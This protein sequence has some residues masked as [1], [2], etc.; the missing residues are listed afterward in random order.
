MS[1]QHV[2]YDVLADL[3]EGLLEELPATSVRAHL[4]E[5]AECRERSADLASV[6]R[7][8]AS[9]PMPPMPESLAA[10]LDAAILAE[11]KEG[12]PVIDLAARRRIRMQRILSV[13]AA[14]TVVSGAGLAI[15]NG[16]LDTGA[17]NGT[18]ALV[19]E[20]REPVPV[21]STKKLPLV[22]SPTQY[23]KHTLAAQV[24]EQLRKTA[25]I[26]PGT[27]PGRL[28]DCVRSVAGASAPVLLV[29]NAWFDGR[30]ATVIVVTEPSSNDMVAYAVGA[31]C[32]AQE[33]DL[34]STVRIAG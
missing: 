27:V 11:A 30:E 10:R 1:G 14:V 31:Q 21:A 22:T 26:R 12:A 5:C 33:Q 18:L 34:F 16:A 4:E 17:G 25:D 19:L 8:L 29:D 7:I 23:K 6:S 3:A 24:E 20:N 9:A 32:S 15:A 13:A 28:L 2:D